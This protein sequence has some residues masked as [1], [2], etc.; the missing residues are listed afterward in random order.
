MNKP[1][2]IALIAIGGFAFFAFLAIMAYLGYALFLKDDID[3]PIPDPFDSGSSE[4][5][6]AFTDEEDFKTYIIESADTSGYSTSMWGMTRG[7]EAIGDM[8]M[9]EMAPAVDEAVGNFVESLG[10]DVPERYSETN[11]QVQG[12][13]EPD[14]V[15]TDGTNIFFSPEEYWYLYRDLVTPMPLLEL[16][17]E[18]M[19]VSIDIE[20]EGETE[21][22]SAGTGVG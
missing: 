13:D 22:G 5:I 20:P 12:I 14:M 17:E 3:L 9:E 15:K 8:T 18:D 1:F 11:V 7:F 6:E 21:P 2:K 10:S 19:T 4:E 16:M